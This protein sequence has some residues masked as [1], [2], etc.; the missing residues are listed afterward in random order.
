MSLQLDFVLIPAGEFLMGSNKRVD[1]KAEADE[2][3][4]HRLAVS[5]YYLMRLPVTNA[6]FSQFLQESGR[7]TPFFWSDKG[8]P[9][10]RSDH[11]VVGV[12]FLDAAAFCVWAAQITGLPLRLP[13]EPEWER[14]ARGDDGRM[15]PWGNEWNAMLCNTF[16]SNLG[17]TT[18]VGMFSPRDHSPFG[19]SDMG[20]NVQQWTAS[21]FGDYP[22]DSSDGRETLVYRLVDPD[23]LPKIRETGGTSVA[24]SPEASLGKIV[25]R[26]GSWRE[27]RLQARCAYRSWAPPM[28]YSLDTGFRCCYEK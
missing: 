14:A 9:P 19:I 24:A 21:H 6:Q 26:G 20:G 15:Y 25:L 2:M 12:T 8:A 23:L 18:P 3:P 5:D 17:D 10:S 16:E 4:Q 1:S 27:S 28:H 13:S 22:Y 11:P 7:R